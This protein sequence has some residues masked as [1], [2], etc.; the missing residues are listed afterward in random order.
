MKSGNGG[1]DNNLFLMVGSLQSDVRN[2]ATDVTEIKN[3]QTENR[4]KLNKESEAEKRALGGISREL[5]TLRK[6]FK[7]LQNKVAQLV[8]QISNIKGKQES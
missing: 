8:T 2:L 1:S 7:A 5:T 4:N 6:D 3:S